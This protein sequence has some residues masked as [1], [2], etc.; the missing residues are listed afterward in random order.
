M[1]VFEQIWLVNLLD[2]LPLDIP[3][4]HWFLHDNVPL[5]FSLVVRLYNCK[6]LDYF[7]WDH[8]GQLGYA[9]PVSTIEVFL[10]PWYDDMKR[11][12]L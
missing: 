11:E 9:K 5:H 7:H 8:L 4:N 10:R 12:L 1:R 3:R 6:P 2:G